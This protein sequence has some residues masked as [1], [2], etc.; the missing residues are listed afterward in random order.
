[1]TGHTAVNFRPS[2][3]EAILTAL[4]DSDG[5]ETGGILLGPPHARDPILVTH[6]IGPGPRALRTY[7]RFERDTA[8]CQE[9]LSDLQQML[10][11][12]WIGDWHSHPD[13]A[14]EPSFKDVLT[15]QSLV[16]DPELGFDSYLMVVV[17]P[18]ATRLPVATAWLFS[19][20]DDRG[21]IKSTDLGPPEFQG[22]PTRIMRW[23]RPVLRNRYRPSKLLINV[24][25][26]RDLDDV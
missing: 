20:E 11:V 7:V 12:E 2:A 18:Q 13:S 4:A 14:F 23:I 6:A 25:D 26:R 21:R 15:A 17:C 1:M 3:R 9:Q 10:P 16:D 19:R 24:A 5:L 22:R 8:W